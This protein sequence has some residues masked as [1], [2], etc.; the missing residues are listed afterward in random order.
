MINAFRN[1]ELFNGCSFKSL[2]TL[3]L[4]VMILLSNHSLLPTQYDLDIEKIEL[5]TDAEPDMDT[6][7]ENNNEK[8][9]T[10]FFSKHNTSKLFGSQYLSSL[11]N[12][13][14]SQMGMLYT[15]IVTPPPKLS[16]IIS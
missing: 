9:K 10:E 14:L 6:E 8:E 12:A 5:T 2:V 3:F 15:D 11:K 1:T 4:L 7:E 13:Q 16:P